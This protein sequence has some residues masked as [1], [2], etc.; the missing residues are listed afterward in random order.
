M[1]KEQFINNMNRQ[2]THTVYDP[3]PIAS[4]GTFLCLI[5][6][7]TAFWNTKMNNKEFYDKTDEQNEI[8][9][10]KILFN[11]NLIFKKKNGGDISFKKNNESGKDCK[12]N[13]SS[14]PKTKEDTEDPLFVQIID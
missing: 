2:L 1:T 3:H 6:M 11:N 13:D 4:R 9:G 10:E 8:N 7:G 5:K 14:P 12:A